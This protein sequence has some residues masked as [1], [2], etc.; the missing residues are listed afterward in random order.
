VKK[1]E[2]RKQQKALKRRSE[3]KLARARSGSAASRTPSLIRQART[4][5][6]E[7]CWA[8]EGWD[9][10]GLAVVV[11]ARRQPTGSITFGTYL[12]DYYCL[13]LKNTFCDANVPRG[14]FY[15]TVLPKL[16][17]EASPVPISADLAHEIVYGGIEYAAQFGFR[18][19]RD[20]ALSQFVLDPPEMHPRTGTVEFG[21]QGMPFYISGPDDNTEAI[22]RQLERNPGPGNYHFIVGLGPFSDPGE[23]WDEDDIDD[24]EPD[25]DE[26]D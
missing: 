17:P 20:F 16:V 4:Y 25:E 5:P 14:E 23:A 2:K 22:R 8:M 26:D 7:G 15:G 10:G 9:Q 18:P 6:L 12:V 24:A 3:R 11:V 1:G 19:Q 21:Y 13:G